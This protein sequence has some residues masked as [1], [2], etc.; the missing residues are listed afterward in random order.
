MRKTERRN[1]LVEEYKKRDLNT[2]L[3]KIE[4]MSIDSDSVYID[5][6]LIK[7]VKSFL[8]LGSLMKLDGTYNMNIRN[9]LVERRPK[10][11]SNVKLNFIEQE[12]NC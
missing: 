3:K 12:Y 9:K 4:Y 8:Y 6:N 5:R 7:K 10:S 1:K 11:N 2:N